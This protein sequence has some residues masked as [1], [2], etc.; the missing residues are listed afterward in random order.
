MMHGLT[1]LKIRCF[2]QSVYWLGF[3]LDDQ[4]I[5]VP[6]KAGRPLFFV[7]LKTS[8]VTHPVFYSNGTRGSLSANKVLEALALRMNGALPLPRRMLRRPIA[9]KNNIT[10][11]L[12][13]MNHKGMR[14]RNWL[15]HCATS[16]KVAGSNT[17]GVIG[18][19]Y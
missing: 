3:C 17:D 11:N 10:F 18:F 13:F 16:R 4:K 14:Q 8:S 7:T 15:R 6:F 5:G 2:V 1:N 19:F 12:V 9:S